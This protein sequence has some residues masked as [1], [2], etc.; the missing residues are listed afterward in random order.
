MTLGAK[1]CFTILMLI[2]QILL[3]GVVGLVLYWVWMFHKGDDPS[4]II[5]LKL[6]LNNNF[7][8][9]RYVAFKEMIFFV[10]FVHLGAWHPFAWRGDPRKEFNLHPVLMIVG[11][12]YCMGQGKPIFR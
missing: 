12:V 4:K 8:Y 6:D 5:N 9:N 2:T 3:H 7:V 1:C 10:T 11:F